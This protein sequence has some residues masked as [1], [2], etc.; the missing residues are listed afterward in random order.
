M[1]GLSGAW[2]GLSVGYGDPFC[3]LDGGRYPLGWVP[4]P[5]NTPAQDNSSASLLANQSAGALPAGNVSFNAS[6]APGFVEFDSSASVIGMA[7]QGWSS[8]DPRTDEKGRHVEYGRRTTDLA[9][10]FSI[11]MFIK[12]ASNDTRSKSADWLPSI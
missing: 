7:H 10:V 9:G 2:A 8:W 12:L 6:L 4:G 5:K 11:E 1:L 3:R